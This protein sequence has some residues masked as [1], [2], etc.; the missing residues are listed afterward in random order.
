MRKAAVVAAIAV[1]STL[2]TTPAFA[3]GF[4]G[5]RLIMTRAIDLLPQELKPFFE[6]FRDEMVVRVV[7]PDLWRNVGWEDDPNHFVDFGMPQLGPYPFAGLPRDYS[8]ALDK[9]GVAELKRIGML[10]WRAAEMYGH[11]RRGF[12]GFNRQSAY[13]TSDVVLFAA[14]T[15]HYVQDAHQPFHATNNYDGQLTGNAGIHSRF[16][17]DLIERFSSR[18]MLAPGAVTP[19]ANPRDRAFETLVD[20]FTHVAPILKADSAAVAGKDAYDDEYFEKFF[21]AVK[22][23]LEKQLSLSI[24]ATAGVIVGAWES[25]GRPTLKTV[26][27]RPLQK[28]R[29]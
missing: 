15:S 27:A 8:Q 4:A 2:A 16:E 10:P 9:F 12:D 28:V 3:W 14:V 6:R 11:L 19:I 21:V 7:D 5:H 22:P 20:S 17:R 29:K 13:G 1:A 23:I 18:L 24:A 25:A 26:D